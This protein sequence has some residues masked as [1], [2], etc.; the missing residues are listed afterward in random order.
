MAGYA[1]SVEVTLHEDGSCE[2]VDDGPRHPC[3][4]APGL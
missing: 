3:G 4:A 2:A 1:T